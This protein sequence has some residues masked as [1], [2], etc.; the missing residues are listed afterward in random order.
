[1]SVELKEALKELGRVVVLAVIPVLI[2]SLENWEIDWKVV[3]VV[4]GIAALRFIDKY[5]H[6]LGLQKE[7]GSGEESKLTL[8][9]TRF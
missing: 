8:G 7:S 6:Q 5:L 1:M 2:A 3:A 4:G 9:L